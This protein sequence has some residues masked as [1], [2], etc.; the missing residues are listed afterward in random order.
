MLS[1]PLSFWRSF[2]NSSIRNA[3]CSISLV[4]CSTC[5]V[6]S[7]ICASRSCT[8]YKKKRKKIEDILLYWPSHSSTLKK[9]KKNRK[10]E[11]LL[12][13]F[14]FTDTETT[15]TEQHISSKVHDKSKA[16]MTKTIKLHG[17]Q[18][19]YTYSIEFR[20]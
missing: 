8:P 7:L 10:R 17:K 18:I 6:S 1:L 2:F 16:T 15:C 9:K 4:Y 5:S 3:F 13:K 20:Y 19:Y 14:P 12:K 11:A